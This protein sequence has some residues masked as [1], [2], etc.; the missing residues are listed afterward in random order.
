MKSRLAGRD[1]LT[2]MDFSKEEVEYFLDT[3]AELKRKQRMRESHEYL[4]GKQVALIFEKH[5]TRTRISFQAGIAQLGAQSF[6]MRPDELQMARGEPIKDTARVIDR[7]CDALVI[8]TFGQERVEEFARWMENPVINA[9]TDLAHP[10]QIL[11]DLL[12]IRE[13]KGSFKG[14]KMAFTGDIWNVCHSL[15]VG[16]SMMGMDIYIARPEAYNPNGHFVKFAHEQAKKRGSKIVITTNLGEAVTDAD[17]V[18]SVAWYSLGQEDVEQK[19]KEFAAYQITEDLLAKAKKDVI[20]MNCLPCHREE[21]VTD[22]VLE[23]SRSV[24][25]DQAENRMHTEKAVLSLVMA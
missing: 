3:A 22:E 4:K 19:K 11:A 16:S 24:V 21:E 9:L 25:W 10:C 1:F 14:L 8:R 20:Y 18:Y 23:G 13:K 6:Y 2:L 15:L 17:I 12:T 7:Y 5:S